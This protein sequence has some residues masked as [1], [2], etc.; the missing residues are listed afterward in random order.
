MRYRNAMQRDPNLARAFDNL[1]GMFA[2]PSGSDFLASAKMQSE[3]ADAA[4]REWLFNNSADPTASARSSLLGIQGYGQTPSG[5]GKTLDVTRRGQD[6]TAATSEANNVRDNQRLIAAKALD[7]LNQDQF[8]P[9][10]ESIAKMYSIPELAQPT[11]GNI[12]AAPGETITTPNN[13]VFRGAPKPMSSDEVVAAAMQAELDSGRVTGRQI[14]GPK[15][16]SPVEVQR[17]DGTRGFAAQGDA[18]LGGMSAP[19]ERKKVKNV[20]TDVNGKQI[21]IFEDGSA[22]FTDGSPVPPDTRIVNTAQPQGPNKDL[23]IGTGNNIT[24]RNRVLANVASTE[25]LLNVYDDIITKNPGAIGLVGAIRGTAQNL[26]ASGSDL[27]KAFGGSVPQIE[28]AQAALRDGLS[29][30]AGRDMFDPSIPEAEFI[31]S[32]LA[33]ALARGENGGSDVSNRDFQN[34]LDRVKGGGMLA[35]SQSA[36]A[37]INAARKSLDA[38]RVRANTLAEPGAAPAQ[39]RSG[40]PA[41]AGATTINTP[42]GVVTIQRVP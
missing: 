4:R 20:V 22:L 37:A 25:T 12:S 23:G 19:V 3:R 10:F 18:I 26:I 32:T 6:I 36:K 13:E 8:R 35:N 15:L 40:A 39:M 17:P 1:A 9:G 33:Y 42:A 14:T 2:P 27:A 34:A 28:A 16:G 41:P 7:P 30:A 31:Q 21:N 11:R 38:Q 5:F 29:K 24:E